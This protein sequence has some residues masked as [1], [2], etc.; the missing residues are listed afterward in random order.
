M[1]SAV[2]CVDCRARL[3]C[4]PLQRHLPHLCSPEHRAPPPPPPLCCDSYTPPAYARPATSGSSA[5]CSG[6]QGVQQAWAAARGRAAATQHILPL[7]AAATWR[8][9]YSCYAS[10]PHPPPCLLLPAR[11]PPLPLAPPR[12]SGGTLATWLYGGPT[13]RRV[14]A[15]SLSERL[16][17]ALDVARG[18][19]ALEQHTPQV[20][21]RDLKPSNVVRGRRAADVL[22]DGGGLCMQQGG[23]AGGRLLEG[24]QLACACPPGFLFP[25]PKALF[26]PPPPPPLEHP[27][28]PPLHHSSSTPLGQQRSRTS[29]WRA[30]C[31]RQPW[32][33]SP[34]R[35]AATCGCEPWA[36]LSA[37]SSW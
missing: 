28:C 11:F 12:H 33:P 27:P 22:G 5:S 26:P 31:R 25:R 3:K 9:T 32:C 36:A 30:S 21:H 1:F 2:R 18:M 24:P 20:L 17:M 37:V 8:A 10:F 13:A 23:G 6:G 16:K 29:G 15:R 19:Q 7:A 34:G 14:P 35:R 4:V